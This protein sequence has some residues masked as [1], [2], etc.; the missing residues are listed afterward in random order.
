MHWSTESLRKLDRLHPAL[1]GVLE[2]ALGYNLM[3]MTIIETVR[4]KEKQ[5]EYY[6]TGKS[7]VRWPYGKHNVTA[8]KP[9]SR[10]V[11]VAPYIAGKGLSWDSRHCL[12]MAGMILA[13]AKEEGVPVR[14]GG[15][16]DMDGEPVTDQDFQDL[17]HFELREV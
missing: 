11:D 10:A 2:R 17:V 4:S 9:L 14:W 3:D 15:N 6:R 8:T 12:F 16:W 13:A 1:V 7:R 5:D